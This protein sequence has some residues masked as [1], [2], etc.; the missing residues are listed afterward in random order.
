[1]TGRAC[2][3]FDSKVPEGYAGPG[4]GSVAIVT[5]HRR[6]D[7]RSGFPLHHV[8][9]VARR[10]TSWRYTIMSKEGRFP[11]GRAMAT[12]T[13]HSRRQMVDRLERGDDSPA[14][15]VALHTLRGGSPEDALYVT[16]LAH[17]LR[18]TPAEREA[19]TAVIDSDI[20]AV[21]SLGN[22]GLRHQQ[23]RAAY[24]QTPDNNCPG[25]EPLSCQAS[26]SSH[27]C[28]CHCATPSCL[29]AQTT[30]KY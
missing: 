10:T 20:R 16:P 5:G 2:A 4:D 7:V 30:I 27:F 25:K 3:R 12:I 24:R 26:H 23:H 9:V 19:R 22:R 13:V 8:V 14:G 15:G 1:M 29:V 21:R 17:H 28:N 11:I 18:V 6:R